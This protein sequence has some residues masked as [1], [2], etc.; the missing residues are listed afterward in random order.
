M[1][2]LKRLY[3]F[4]V[5]LF[6]PSMLLRLAKSP[7][8]YLKPI[9][10]I[11]LF[12]NTVSSQLNA[13]ICGTSGIDGP[14][15][16]LPPINTYFPV[17]L[18]TALTAGSKSLV[19]QAV[20]PN[21][22]NYNLSYGVTQI[23]PGDLI[24]IIQM[25]DATFN[26]NNSNLYGSGI[27]NSGLDNLGGTGFTDIGSSGKYE[28]VVATS[29]VP[30][31]GGLL[32]FRGAG[33]GQGAVNTYVNENFTATRGQRRFQ[34]IRVPQYST[35][36]LS[37]NLTTPP[38]NG[39][40]GG[41]IA[42]DV[43]GSM[44]FNGFSID[45]SER[46]FRGGYGPVAG[47]G[48]NTNSVYAVASS[49]TRSVGKGE[50]I[51]GTP[52][53]M[54]DGFNQ[55]DNLVE[56][57]P[58]GSYGRG[59]PANAGGAGND[60]NAG[61]GGG[62]NGGHGGIGGRGWQGAGGNLNPLTGG[63]R[64]GH[65]L[66]VDLSRLIMGGGGGGG[67]ANNATSGVKGGVGGGI[68]LINVEKIEGFGLVRSNGGTG[69]AGAFGSAPDG[70]GGGGAGG[71]IFIRSLAPSATAN[72]II[73]AKGG[74]GGNT[75]NDNNNAHGPGG[76]GGGG[77]I[78]TQVP[79][80]TINTNIVKGLS[81]KSNN[82]SGI[83]HG[84]EDGNDGISQNF[85]TG[86]LPTHLQGG[87]SICYPSLDVTLTELNAGPAGIRNAGTTATY[88]LRVYNNVGGGNAGEV[89]VDFELPFGFSLTNVTQ[90]LSGD[91][92][93]TGAF[94]FTPGST[95]LINFGTYN[96]SPGDYV[97]Y[98]IGVNIASNLP[99]G[100]YHA[101]AQATYLD[102]TRTNANPV[103]KITASNQAFTGNNTTYETG[104]LGGLPVTGTNYNG[105]LLVSS[106]EDVYINANVNPGDCDAIFD[107]AF[108]AAPIGEYD[109][110]NYYLKK[111]S[112]VNNSDKVKIVNDGTLKGALIRDNGTEKFSLKQTVNGITE[113][114]SYTLTFDY[115]NWNGSS[116]SNA[117]SKFQVEILDSATNNQIFLSNEFIAKSSPEIATIN[118]TTFANTNSLI[119]KIY[120]PGS[121]NNAC[122][123]FIDNISI[124][125]PI[126]VQLATQSV[127]CFG[128]N[129][130][131]LIISTLTGAS[132]PYKLSYSSDG[133][134]NYS[135]VINSGII[136]NSNPYQISNL[137]AGNYL[138][139]IVDEN[140]CV[141]I[142]P[143]EI[144]QPNSLTL[145][146]TNTSILCY[147]AYSTVTLT[148]GG[149]VSPYTYSIDGVNF[150]TQNTF[151]DL[152][153]G[154]YSFTVKD[155]NNCTRNTNVNIIGPSAIT[156]S[157]NL[158]SIKCFGE[159]AQV[160]L[161]ASGGTGTFS[162]SMDGTNFQASNIFTGVTPG[163]QVFTVK[164]GNDC[165]KTVLVEVIE[166]DTLTLS[167]SK[168]DILCFG[169]T[170]TV[171]IS[172]TGGTGAYQF[173]KDGGVNFQSGNSFSG[174]TAGNY[175]FIVKD[176]NDC[177][178][179]VNVVITE[180]TVL[181]LSASKTDILCFGG[182]ST[183]TLSAT[184]GN[185]TY[186]FSKDGGV[187]FV[188]SNV[189][190]G[191]AAGNYSFIVKDANNCLMTVQLSITE[192]SLLTLSATKTNIL[193]FGETSTVTLSATGGTG[194]Y[195]FS[196]DG[197]VTFVSSNSFSGLIAGNYSFIVKD[198]NNC[199]ATVTVSIAEPSLLTLSASKTDILCFGGTSTVTL[200]ATGGTGAYQFSKDGGT[201]FVS[202]NVFSG[203]AAGNYSFIV[204][205]AN[206]CATTIAVSI[207]E[208]SI[209]S[210][211]ASKTD[212]LCFGGT[213]TV[214]LSATGGTGT[215][216]FSKDGGVTFVSSNVFSGLAAGN[217]SFIVKDA[218]ECATTIA[219]SIT[220]PSALTVSASKTD[221][222]CFGETSTVTLSATGG[223]GTYLFSKDGGATFVSSNV[224][225]G[226]AAGNY[227]FIVKDTNECA[228]T[229][230]VSITEPSALTVSA[231]KTDILCFGET[232]TV[233]LSATGGTGAYLF[234]K[235]G[236][237]TF[238]SSNVFSGLAAGNYSFIVKD[239]NNCLVTVTVSIVEPVKINLSAIKTNINCK[240]GTAHVTLSVSGGNGPYQYSK[241]GISYQN[242]NIFK[243]LFAGTYIF[244]VRDANNCIK[245]VEIV[246]TEPAQFI[247][248]SSQTNILCKG[249][250]AK[251]TLSATGGS[252]M[253]QYSKDGGKT[254]QNINIFDGL[255]AGSYSFTAKDMNNCTTSTNVV[256]SEPTSLIL[257]AS[258]TLILCKSGTSELTLTAAGGAGTYQY[259]KDAGESFQSSNSFT[260]L[261][262][263]NYNFIVKDANNCQASVN[264][265]ITEPTAL[266]VSE[267]HSDILC[268]G[269]NN[270][271]INL[272]I[273]GGTA[274]YTYL[275][276]NGSTNKDLENLPGGNYN[277]RVTDAN[278][279]VITK[280]IQI[281]SPTAP[282]SIK[283][284]HQNNICFG[285][286]NG[287]INIT[288]T[289][290]TA[291]YSYSWSNGSKSKDLAGLPSG[292]YELTVTDK[293]NCSANIKV[294][295]NPLT[296]FSVSNQVKQI[297]CFG[298]KDGKIS[299]TLTGG[300]APYT[301]KWSNGSTGNKIENL[302]LGTYTYTAKDALGCQ[303]SGAVTI[304]QPQP[305]TTK[306]IIKN[307]TCKF[308]PDG[309]IIIEVNGGT[310]PYKFLWN[311]FDRGQDNTL[312]N[313]A[314]GK[315]NVAVIDANNC[316]KQIIAEVLPGNCA[317]N[318][319]DD[320]YST[321]EDTPITIQT[322]GIILNDLDP[323]DDNLL[324]SLSS[325]MDPDVKTG[326]LNNVH[327]SFRTKNGFVSLNQNGSFTY[328]PN[329]NFFGVENF[330]YKVTD[331][332]LNSNLAIV[333][334]RV[335]AVNDPP[336]ARNDFY[337]T[338]EDVP[339]SG[340]VFPNDSDPDND[341]LR[342]TLVVPP[343]IGSLVFQADGTFVY[344][345]EN[346]FHGVVTFSYQVCD[347][348]GLCD[349]AVATI[350][351]TPVN[352]PP[353][354]IDDLF[355]IQRNLQISATVAPNDKDPDN[356]PLIFSLI[357]QPTNGTI[358]FNVNGSFT[359]QPRSG[360]KGRDTFNYRICDP[361][362][363]CDE[364]TVDLIIQPL[365]TVKLT[366]ANGVINE[367]E[368]IDIT[369]E[370]NESIFQDVVVDI[371]FSGSATN[372]IDYTLKGNFIQLT[373]P[374]GQ[375]TT[376][377]KF[378]IAA[379]LDDI[380]DD[381]EHVLATISS[382]NSPTF[383]SIGTGSDVLI[384]DVYPERIPSLPSENPDINPDPQTSPNGDGNGND[385]FIIYN[386]NNYPDNEV[387]IFNRWG[388]EVYKTKKYNNKDN[389]FRGVA[390]VG[391][392]SNTN[393]ELVDGVYYYIIYTT[394]NGERKMNK[395]Y[396]ILKR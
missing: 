148:A 365:V 322:P 208:P 141:N 202:S 363:L 118:F 341:P 278:N 302:A 72:L 129:N 273:S 326:T 91:A 159:T 246:I 89:K 349:Q 327:T 180:P 63:G 368:N 33:A 318:A 270:G 147:G 157:A 194:A 107:G 64:P 248:S 281:Q 381:N 191:L 343:T 92:V 105:N 53:F 112:V 232:S 29:F 110:P 234:S 81:G 204:K 181:T 192:P 216:L 20:P 386:I 317:P 231:A 217:Y 264:V 184:G 242:E 42:F 96:I 151:P 30:L 172:A 3:L 37:S 32:T 163:P 237:T 100:I 126:S 167:A 14:Q 347:P 339:V 120:D 367:G 158:T 57:L 390:N 301:V 392:L 115:R 122:G 12:V 335:N 308:S 260:G 48:N 76:G 52:R 187:T 24:L 58:G 205:D 51:G 276:S 233:T 280:S 372:N 4:I 149:G 309:A 374:S 135:S 336:I 255:L 294:V 391:I 389:S 146:T 130:G 355:Y 267:N 215:Y 369:A 224:F 123:A 99:T 195:Q 251:V 127:T 393:K 164:D 256:I 49:S 337:T 15:N 17:G 385:S 46:G 334:I 201:T 142:T 226:L 329:R 175:S 257:T 128:S 18:N 344:T 213:S 198:A 121:P 350:T 67:D 383:V 98:T 222:L 387:I 35:L 162:Y 331:G 39:S 351:V 136:T 252:G 77:F 269:L 290:G 284:T 188:S 243:D 353:V 16:A 86:Q 132:G 50:G 342:Y 134:T 8:K 268:F 28:Y 377:Q 249:G 384:K 7:S 364:A 47:S 338:A 38:Y 388:N 299:L 103:R 261:I 358:T 171:T 203:L 354:A 144:T 376:T 360:F 295:I 316:S 277:V 60:H 196:K 200:S 23:K 361:F 74:N 190:A 219:V 133:G 291:P 218:N 296:K 287:K 306:S 186:Q 125:S 206:E 245:S 109:S 328:T 300:E 214:T 71:S 13:Q 247:L 137:L 59:A 84:A 254:Y 1:V 272:N 179:T 241:D 25:Q 82:G 168:T 9:F 55:V 307:S 371:Q 87:G 313:I 286:V 321:N 170:S 166:P 73:E 320:A 311:G 102:P 315:Y 156:L 189:F 244:N 330:V 106:L 288:V 11:F 298:E 43:A 138:L 22:P 165:M 101:S 178:S 332:S 289:G 395:G 366:P 145:S 394:V 375:T 40:V 70:A 153:A 45:A 88:I 230:A 259:S 239:A 62:A 160:N 173:S 83:N 75:K 211:S 56:G 193:C 174:L 225:S 19:L 131:K 282:L 21:D 266:I 154:N 223:T 265:S 319:S 66:P 303:I 253:Y 182:T 378:N 5:I 44:Q 94:A 275:W 34:V 114:S 285:D 78:Y 97:E 185:G 283:E 240:G 10:L 41:V 117:A 95:G 152:P 235:D 373:I 357:T 85:T 220:E 197:G 305:L 143:F 312:L 229:I 333:T 80:A 93:N 370:L 324:V 212:I 227:S 61:G 79:S 236:G 65:V 263:G 304:T 26:F 262:A 140:N 113:L 155:V 228:K 54:W 314:P 183:V 124:T 221:I 176:A 293:N 111:W 210:L 90:T 346:N 379:L 297:S 279:C 382:T 356:D 271:K 325:A 2:F 199:S 345:P 104:G 348:N 362:G 31:T 258:K 292:N 209:L 69:Q 27:A 116:C 177:S 150:V 352:D 6:T 340:T 380:K 310:A 323:D 207:T 359:Y 36:V 139:K 238:V 169:G 274:P 68:I 108:D 161:I 119:I 250:S 396:L